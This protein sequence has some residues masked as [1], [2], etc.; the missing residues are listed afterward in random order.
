MGDLKTEFKCDILFD[1]QLRKQR[2]I[3]GMKLE[4]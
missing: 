2:A 3:A 4:K 1:N